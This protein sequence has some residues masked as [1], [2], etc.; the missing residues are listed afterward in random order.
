ME[1]KNSE[2]R[3]QNAGS[4]FARPIP[5]VNRSIARSRVSWLPVEPNGHG[6]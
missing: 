5:I 6:S 4:R 3:S 1:K 2:A